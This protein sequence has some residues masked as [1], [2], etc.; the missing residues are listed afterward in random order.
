MIWQD[1]VFSIGSWIFIVS[2]IPSF[3]KKEY[4][5]VG[6]SLLTGGVLAAFM[7]TYF[8][9]GL[10]LAGTSTLLTSL[11]WLT[12]AFLKHKSSSKP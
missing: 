9:L 8:S 11:C 2:F 12:M 6:T 10:P 3:Y 7:I 1:W 5:A 4:P